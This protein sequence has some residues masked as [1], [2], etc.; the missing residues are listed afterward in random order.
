MAEYQYSAGTC[1]SYHVEGGRFDFPRNQKTYS[2]NWFLIA[3]EL[4]D[5][6]HSNH[7]GWEAEWPLEL[8]IY[9]EGKE[10]ARFSVEREYEPTFTPREIE[11]PDA[12]KGD[13]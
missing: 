3:D 10:V 13:A 4:A 2:E 1:E 12:L 8:R 6:F 5:D 7:D 11:T 9:K